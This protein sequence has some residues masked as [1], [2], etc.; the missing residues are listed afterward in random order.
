MWGKATLKRQKSSSYQRVR[1][2]SSTAMY[3]RNHIQL[4]MLSSFIQNFAE[5]N[6]LNMPARLPNYDNPNLKLL[7]RSMTKKY[8]VWAD[9]CQNVAIQLP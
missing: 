5:N 2:Q 1:V 8:Q 6:A 9:F 3:T 7:T 4:T